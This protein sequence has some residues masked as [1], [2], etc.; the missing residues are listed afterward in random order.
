MEVSIH[1]SASSRDEINEILA[2]VLANTYLLFI[3]T[4]FYHWNVTGPHFFSY[5]KMFEEQYE[6][7]FEAIDGLAE[8]IRAL[9]MYAEGST[10]AFQQRQFIDEDDKI[11]S[12]KDMIHQLVKSHEQIIG[13]LR[14]KLPKVEELHDGATADLINKRLDTHEKT[15]WMLRSHI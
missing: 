11:H 4:Q 9:G 5:H 15:A 10:K 6:E 13:Y 8:R 1:L 12:A 2:N 14:E 7:L 3:K